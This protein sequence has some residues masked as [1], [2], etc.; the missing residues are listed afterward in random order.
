[1]ALLLHKQGNVAT[2]VG[3]TVTSRKIKMMYDFFHLLSKA[4]AEPPERCLKILHFKLGRNTF[5]GFLLNTKLE[6]MALDESH[7]TLL[8]ANQ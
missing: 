8:A 7:V 5:S 6:G 4:L 1:M 3:T 2:G